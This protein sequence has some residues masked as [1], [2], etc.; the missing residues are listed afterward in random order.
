MSYCQQCADLLRERGTLLAEVERLTPIEE[1]LIQV[2]RGGEIML[3]ELDTLRA[4][5]AEQEAAIKT[6][7]K[8]VEKLIDKNAEQ[9]AALAELETDMRF[10]CTDQ[11]WIGKL[12]VEDWANRIAALASAQSVG[13]GPQVAAGQ[14]GKI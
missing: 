14:T 6:A 7:T 9:G 2:L 12:V 4:T 13:D 10:R 5:V 3:A 8:A 11:D 1:R